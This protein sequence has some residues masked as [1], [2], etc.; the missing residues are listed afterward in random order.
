[1]DLFHKK[2]R[3]VFN[4][5]IEDLSDKIPQMKCEAFSM[6][7]KEASD[8]YFYSFRIVEHNDDFLIGHKTV[9]FEFRKDLKHD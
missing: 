9:I 3:A 7:D 6:R 8:F 5:P 4:L 1:M 2:Y